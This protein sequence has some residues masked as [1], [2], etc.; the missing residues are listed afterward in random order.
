VPLDAQLVRAATEWHLTR[1]QRGVLG[2][3]AQGLSKRNSQRGASL[4]ENSRAAR[5][6]DPE[7]RP[8]GLA[9]SSDRPTLELG[10]LGRRGFAEHFTCPRLG[11][12]TATTPPRSTRRV[13]ELLE[14]V[15]AGV[16]YTTGCRNWRGSSAER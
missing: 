7:T 8:R 11:G 2:M 14:S 1:T 5:K 12:G 10:R 3:L 16:V 13:A 6:R 15:R 9:G 4:R